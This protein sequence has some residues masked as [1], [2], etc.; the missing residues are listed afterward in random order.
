MILQFCNIYTNIGQFNFLFNYFS[1]M[2]ERKYNKK[3]TDEKYPHPPTTYDYNNRYGPYE[4]QYYPSPNFRRSDQQQHQHYHQH[5]QQHSDQQQHQHPQHQHHHQHPQ[6]HHQQS[7]YKP[8]SQYRPEFGR[9]YRP[10]RL[11]Y[12]YED[13]PLPRSQY[14]SECPRFEEEDRQQSQVQ[15]HPQFKEERQRSRPT[16]QA[17][18]INLEE[19]QYSQLLSETQIRLYQYFIYFIISSYQQ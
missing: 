2:D 8:Q 7:I 6:Q 13:E 9:D 18:I 12:P 17:E 1:N 19:G 15:Y 4:S 11:Q 10:F 3:S 16:G 5:P 14:C